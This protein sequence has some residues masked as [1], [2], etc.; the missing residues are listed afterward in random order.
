MSFKADAFTAGP[1]RLER[2]A[3]RGL[4]GA[5]CSGRASARV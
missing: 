3:A 1:I 4:I 2:D 5:G